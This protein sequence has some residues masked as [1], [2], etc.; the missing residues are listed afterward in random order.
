MPPRT[1]SNLSTHGVHLLTPDRAWIEIGNGPIVL[2]DVRDGPI[3]LWM[4]RK[5]QRLANG[6]RASYPTIVHPRYAFLD[7]RHTT[8]FSIYVDLHIQAQTIAVDSRVLSDEAAVQAFRASMDDC[9]YADND[10]VFYDVHCRTVHVHRDSDGYDPWSARHYVPFLS[11]DQWTTE[12]R[13]DS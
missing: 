3:D 8:A 2:F 9:L 12:W 7:N 10:G 13:E 1:R 5:V 11:G 4:I 6:L